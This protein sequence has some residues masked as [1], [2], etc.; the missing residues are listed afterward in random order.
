MR[1][2]EEL[3]RWIRGPRPACSGCGE[4]T[5]EAREVEQGPNTGWWCPWCVRLMVE[6]AEVIAPSRTVAP[7][8]MVTTGQLGHDALHPG[9]VSTCA[10]CR[11]RWG[12]A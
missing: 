5:P 9:F 3:L 12:V 4:R 8:S 11:V 1:T 10:A 6:F 7:R 2:A